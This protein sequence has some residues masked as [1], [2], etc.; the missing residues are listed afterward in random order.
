MAALLLTNRLVD[1]AAK[2]L[3]ASE[4]WALAAKVPDLGVLLDVDEQSVVE[5]LG[6]DTT[7][8]KRVADSAGRDGS[9][10]LRARAAGRRRHQSAVDRRD[11]TAQ[12]AP[13]PQESFS[14]WGKA[15]RMLAP[16]SIT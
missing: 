13:R 12:G 1:V 9:V 3:G 10:R 7:E 6:G 14:G 16:E 5:L 11:P 15:R 8:A 4:Y 2:P